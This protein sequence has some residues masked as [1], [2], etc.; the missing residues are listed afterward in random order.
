MIQAPGHVGRDAVSRAPGTRTGA[1][2]QCCRNQ[3]LDSTS[4]DHVSV[5]AEA[6]QH[7]HLTRRERGI[8]AAVGPTSL[9]PTE[10]EKS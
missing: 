2:E 9:D 7:Q 5:D 8:H 4:L 6:A 10:R 3:A 1:G